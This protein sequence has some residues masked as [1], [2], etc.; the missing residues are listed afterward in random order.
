MKKSPANAGLSHCACDLPG[1]VA[2]TH[3]QVACIAQPGEAFAQPLDL[4][5]GFARNFRSGFAGD[6]LYVHN[7]VAVIHGHG[8]LKCGLKTHLVVRII[9]FACHDKS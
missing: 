6:V 7:A 5:I 1:K 3:L 9:G 8:I 4:G 2:I